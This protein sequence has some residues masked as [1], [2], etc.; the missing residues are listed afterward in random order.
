M[1]GFGRS[2]SER[3]RRGGPATFEAEHSTEKIVMAVVVQHG[4]VLLRG[5]RGD[6]RVLEWDPMIRFAERSCS[7]RLASRMIAGV[8]GAWRKASSCVS[9]SSKSA[10]LRA[11][12]TISRATIGETASRLRSSAASQSGA[13]NGWSVYS[14]I[15]VSNR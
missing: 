3:C 13:I 1:G 14:Q 5:R 11:V 2:W 6:H 8:S 9:S 12:Y 10:W 4:H 15:D 7:A